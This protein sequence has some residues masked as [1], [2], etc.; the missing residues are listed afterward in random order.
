MCV[1]R[2]TTESAEGSLV[3]RGGGTLHPQVLVLAAWGQAVPGSGKC[4]AG[5]C[6]IDGVAGV[7]RFSKLEQGPCRQGSRLR[8]LSFWSLRWPRQGQDV[9]RVT[10]PHLM[11]P[12]SV[13]THG[14]PSALL[15]PTHLKPFP[16]PCFTT[17]LRLL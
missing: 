14:P 10:L 1:V 7:Y 17:H 11:R 3:E 16:G 12:N 6:C 13:L 15:T 5:K 9:A 2:G 4:F 8:K